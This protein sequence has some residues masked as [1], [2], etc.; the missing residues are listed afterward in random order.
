MSLR[1]LKNFLLSPIRQY[2]IEYLPFSLPT[3][4]KFLVFF[5]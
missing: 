5:S 1:D 3:S 4:V 2:L